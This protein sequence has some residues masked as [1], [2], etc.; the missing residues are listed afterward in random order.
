MLKEEVGHAD[1]NGAQF[2][3]LL[4]DFGRYQMPTARS[5]RKVYRSLQPKHGKPLGKDVELNG[6]ERGRDFEAGVNLKRAAKRA[7]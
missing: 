2:G 5:R 4:E 3:Q 6:P 1:A 7:S